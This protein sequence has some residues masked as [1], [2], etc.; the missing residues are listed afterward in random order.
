MTEILD[1]QVSARLWQNPMS[2]ELKKC[3][4]GH[5]SDHIVIVLELYLTENEAAKTRASG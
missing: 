2:V 4:R 5:I 1:E 3:K